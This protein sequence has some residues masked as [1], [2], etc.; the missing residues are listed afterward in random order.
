MS[1]SR[2]IPAGIVALLW[3]NVL[4]VLAP[5][6]DYALGSPF[7]IVRNTLD[8]DSEHSGPAWYSAIL[9]FCAGA[10]FGLLALSAAAQQSLARF[11]PVAA[12]AVVCIA[13]SAE[14]IVGIHEWLGRQSDALLPGG[15]RSNIALSRTGIWPVLV[16]IP[17][18]IILFFLIRNMRRL[19]APAPRAFILL[20][21]GLAIMFTGALAVELTSN[22]L[23]APR[24]ASA[25]ALLQLAC[26][27]FLE[28]TGTT[29]VVWSAHELLQA[30]GFRLTHPSLTPAVAEI[31]RSR[32]HIDSPVAS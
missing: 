6:I 9:W 5:V 1:S 25:A 18:L 30:Y 23:A 21:I 17:V 10:L 2:R 8:L 31:E 27:E 32:G 16:G 14:E 13:F 24:Q 22:L 29:F 7:A 20:A 28:M 4:V 15:D 11:A 3:I 19:F 12:F 26:E